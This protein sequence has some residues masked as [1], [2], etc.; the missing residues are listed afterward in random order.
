MTARNIKVFSQEGTLF[1]TLGDI[2][3]GE[4]IIK[5]EGITIT[6]TNKIICTSVAGLRLHIF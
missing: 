5:P 4:E 6:Y 3:D 1:H 2:Q